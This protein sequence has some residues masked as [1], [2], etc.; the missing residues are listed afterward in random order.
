MV[1]LI[2][3][4]IWINYSRQ[5]VKWNISAVQEVFNELLTPTEFVKANK[6][7]YWWG[8]Y[9]TIF[10]AWAVG[11]IPAMSSLEYADPVLYHQIKY[12]D[13]AYWDD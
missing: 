1:Y 3:E 2:L 8:R 4:K 10:T 5:N 13:F 11:S 6:G 7:L 9:F 12:F